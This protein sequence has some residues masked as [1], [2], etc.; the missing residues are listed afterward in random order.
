MLFLSTVIVLAL[1]CLIIIHNANGETELLVAMGLPKIHNL[2]PL[3]TSVGDKIIERIPSAAVTKAP[4]SKA[5]VS[6]PV[7]VSS[8]APISLVTKAPVS[9]AP[10]PAP[11]FRPPT[12]APSPAP[13]PPT[14]AF[15]PILYH[16]VCNIL[17]FFQ[18]FNV[19]K[20]I[21]II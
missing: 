4:V 19:Q 18:K 11:S 5:P 20:L 15:I 3:S 9:N 8:K 13:T 1:S 7:S 12:K 16:G 14:P 17:F 21:I 2:R 10:V 6:A